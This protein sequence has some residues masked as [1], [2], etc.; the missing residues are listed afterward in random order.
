MGE[1]KKCYNPGGRPVKYPPIYPNLFN[2]I[3]N[4]GYTYQSFAEALG[5]S[6]NRISYIMSGRYE[7]R[8]YTIDMIL[9]FTGLPYEIAFKEA[10]IGQKSITK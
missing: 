3:K 7:P 8:K 2:W 9:E 6:H 10:R 1:K 4:S 5:V